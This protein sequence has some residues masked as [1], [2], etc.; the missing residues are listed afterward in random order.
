VK[1]QKIERALYDRKEK[2]EITDTATLA[3]GGDM[4][5][6]PENCILL[7]QKVLEEK[8]VTYK[9]DAATFFKYATIEEPKQ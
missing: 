9:M 2:K 6:L 4:P 5:D 8:E 3:T 1:V 7:E